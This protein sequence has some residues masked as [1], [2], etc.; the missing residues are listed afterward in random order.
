AFNG[1]DAHRPAGE[2][3]NK[4]AYRWIAAIATAVA[5]TARAADWPQFGGDPAHSGN[6]AA[7]WQIGASNVATLHLAYRV[8]LP[9]AAG[10]AP[11]LLAG[12]TTPSGTTDV[13]FLTKEDGRVLAGDAARG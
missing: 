12:A 6:N 9:A 5:A 7:E 8:A 3:M 10:G 11:V 13:L 1:A 4:R 2:G